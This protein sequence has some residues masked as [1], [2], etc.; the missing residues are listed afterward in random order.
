MLRIGNAAEVE[1]A[2]CLV[3]ASSPSY[4]KASAVNEEDAGSKLLREREYR[5]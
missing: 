4:L 5:S 1:G 2:V 3:C